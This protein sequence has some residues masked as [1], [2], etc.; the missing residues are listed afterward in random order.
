MYIIS[1]ILK[2]IV[3]ISSCLI[4]LMKIATSLKYPYGELSIASCSLENITLNVEDEIL[5]SKTETNL[6]GTFLTFPNYV[7]VQRCVGGCGYTGLDNKLREC[8]P[9]QMVIRTVNQIV[10]TLGMPK[11]RVVKV[12]EHTSCKCSCKGNHN[13]TCPLAN[14]KFNSDRC[15]CVCNNDREQKN[16]SARHFSWGSMFWDETLCQCR[17]PQFISS[18]VQLKNS[19]KLTCPFGL[20]FSHHKCRCVTRERKIKLS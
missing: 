16:C 20:E 12:N 4:S 14:Q 5:N 7:H 15:R 1:V 17:C 11:R 6:S 3:I 2:I 9:N 8:V 13:G 18:F 19:S 10:Q